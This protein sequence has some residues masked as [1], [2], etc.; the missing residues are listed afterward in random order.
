MSIIA[1]K[2]KLADAIAR[3][4][5]VEGMV[6]QLVRETDFAAQAISEE[7]VFGIT[8]GSDLCGLTLFRDQI[9]AMNDQLHKALL[10][11]PECVAAMETLRSSSFGDA[12]MPKPRVLRPAQNLRATPTSESNL[13]EVIS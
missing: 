2:I 3:V 9:N 12:P 6:R 7:L 13:I 8:E 4:A 11:A 10:A 5:L 1:D